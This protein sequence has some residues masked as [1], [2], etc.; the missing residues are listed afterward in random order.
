[1]PWLGATVHLATT[2]WLQL[3]YVTESLSGSSQEREKCWTHSLV[4]FCHRLAKGLVNLSQ[5][6][7]NLY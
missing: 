5:S 2:S 7:T 3:K 6:T 1:M 4:D